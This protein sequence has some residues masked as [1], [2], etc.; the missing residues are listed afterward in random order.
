MRLPALPGWVVGD[1]ASVRREV[2]GLA[3]LT[4]AERWAATRLCARDALW[5]LR[6]SP[7]PERVLAHADRLPESSRVALARLRAQRTHR[8]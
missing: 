1:A 6:Q 3:G 2:A 4:S 7:D 5:A 8:A